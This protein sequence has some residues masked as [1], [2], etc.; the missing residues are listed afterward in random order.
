M[1]KGSLVFTLAHDCKSVAFPLI[2]AGAYGYSKQYTFDY[3]VILS[4]FFHTYTIEGLENSS[5]VVL[6]RGGNYVKFIFATIR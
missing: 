1:S 5:S 3:F 6:W 2:S 4:F